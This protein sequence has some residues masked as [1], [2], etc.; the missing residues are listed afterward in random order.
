MK[1]VLSALTLGVLASL[2]GCGYLM[3]EDGYFRDRGSDYQQAEVQP[4]MTVPAGLESKPTGDLLPVPGQIAA[5]PQPGEKFETPRPRPMAAGVDTSTFSLQQEGSQRWVL[6]QLPASDVWP[7]LQRFWSDYRVPMAQS[8]AALSEFATQWV[9]FSK[10]A[11]NPLVRRMLPLVQEGQRIDDE[12]QRFRLR[13]EPGVNTGTAEIKV[14]HQAR[15][16]G[17]DDSEWPTR[18]DN[19]NFER[20]LLAE[21][22]TYLNQSV[23][24]DGPALVSSI[25]NSGPVETSLEQDG[26][27]NSVLYMLTDFNR[28]WSDVGEALARADVLVTDYNRSSGV[29]YVDLDQTRSEQ[30][31]E[32]GFF[33]RWFGGDDEEEQVE[34]D[35]SQLQV[36]L[37]PASNRIEVSVDAGIEHAADSASARDLLERIQRGLNERPPRQ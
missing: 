34:D 3:G 1:P 19:V 4:R 26:A 8:D 31:E 22:E 36:R 30:E 35:G 33:S 32:P 24:S 18:S 17:D 9:D 29:Y 10:A 27:G 16:L 2:S 12:E 13:L 20:A 21:L 37:T 15:D 11:G 23:S 28:A 6:A 5:A 7:L 14:L 25:I